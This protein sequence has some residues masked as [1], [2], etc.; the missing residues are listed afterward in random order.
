MSEKSKRRK[1]SAEFCAEAVRRLAQTGNITGL[2]LELGIS[3]Q[4][5]YQWRERVDKERQ[6]GLM[7]SERRLRMENLE[8]KKALLK[9]TLE[10]DFFK[11]ALQKV[12]ALSQGSNGSGATASGKPS[13]N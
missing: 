2:C 5:L 11:T 7:S 1:F 3:H 10:V 6:K 13:G 9:K 12:E 8:L 4:L